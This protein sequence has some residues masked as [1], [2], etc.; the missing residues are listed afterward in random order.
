MQTMTKTRTLTFD[1][2]GLPPAKSEAQSMLG[3][4]HPHAKRVLALLAAARDAAAA[5]GAMHF[6]SARFGMEVVMTLASDRPSDATNYLGGIADVLEEKSHRGVLGHLDAL[7]TV[8]LYDN[9]RQLDEVC[10]RQERGE[11]TCYRVC[12]YVL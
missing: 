12:L 8:A 10:F 9:D 5:A 11:R 6:G 2:D 7:A 1:V 3:A 4:G